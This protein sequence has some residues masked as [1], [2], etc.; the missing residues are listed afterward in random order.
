MKIV[1][2]GLWHLGCVTA[3]CAA[4]YSEVVGIDFDADVV[5]DLA[6]GKAPIQEPGLDDLLKKGIGSGSLRFTTDPSDACAAADVLWLAYDTPVDP[7][8]HADVDYVLGRFRRC[9]KSLPAGA[10]V[11]ISS[12]LPVGTCA[13]LEKEFPC[14]RFACSPENLRLGKALDIFLRA[15]R[16]VVGCRDERSREQLQ[17]LFQPFTEQIIFMRTESAEMVKHAL[18]AFLALSITF[19]NE[20]GRICE[21]TGAD[22]A[23]VAR[24]LKSDI[25]IGSRAYLGAGGPFAGGTL[26][27]DVV[28]LTNLATEHGFAAQVIP[29]IKRSNDAHRHWSFDVLHRELGELR[30]REIAVLGL[31]YKPGTNT[32]RRS[33][34][35]ELALRLAEAGAVVRAFDPAIDALPESLAAIRLAPKLEQAVTGASAVVISTPWPQF[36]DADWRE[37][38]GLLQAP[39]LILDADRFLASNL[40][41]LPVRH[42]SVGKKS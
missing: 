15:D 37:L 27:R 33:A 28:T 31:T 22:A 41:G 18:N 32:L 16:V 39:A 14:L 2:L 17:Q 1:V 5:A 30:G 8:D 7:D 42:L 38:A 11:L 40:D 6:E 3:A 13:S 4:Q 19:A 36:R 9:A 12:Q 34:A 26:A 35:V 24:G 20:I 10:L 29:A 25:R 23:E 21:V